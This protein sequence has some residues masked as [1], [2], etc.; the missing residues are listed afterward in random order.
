M[1]ATRPAP[2]PLTF[3]EWQTVYWW[4]NRARLDTQAKR[5]DGSASAATLREAERIEARAQ[6]HMNYLRPRTG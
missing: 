1:A 3:E 4:L 5:R 6:E 2:E